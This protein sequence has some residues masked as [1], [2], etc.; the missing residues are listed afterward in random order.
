M[1][2]QNKSLTK[3]LTEKVKKPEQMICRG[4]WKLKYFILFC[5]LIKHLRDILCERCLVEESM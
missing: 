3:R 5:T 1:Y 4:V 2:S